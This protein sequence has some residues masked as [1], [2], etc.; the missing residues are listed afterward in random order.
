MPRRSGKIVREPERYDMYNAF[1]YTYT[2]VIDEFDNDPAFY[3]KAMASS[4]ANLW[5][6]AMNAEI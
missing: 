2:A 5:Q 3:S 4:E 6:K 1:G